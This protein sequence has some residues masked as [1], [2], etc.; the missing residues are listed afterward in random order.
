VDLLSDL[1]AT[2]RISGAVL[3]R[4]ELREPWG[5]AIPDAREMAR[6]LP[7]CVKN[8]IPFHI[9]DEGFFWVHSADGSRVRISSGEAVL[10]PRG[11]GHRLGGEKSSATEPVGAV[12]PHPP[13]EVAPLVRHG[14]N[15]AVAR[16]VCGFVGCEDPLLDPFLRDLPP[17]LHARPGSDPRAR[18]LETA[19]RYTAHEAERP[20]PGSRSVLSRLVELMFVE[21]LR[22]AMRTAGEIGVGWLAASGDPVVG[23]GGGALTTIHRAPAD[24][25]TVDTLAR[26]VGVSRTV[27][28][29]RFKRRLGLPPMHYLA[30][31]RLRVAA[32]LLRRT[33]DPLKGIA[34]RTGYESEAAFGR[35][36]KRHFGM[37]PHGWRRESQRDGSGLDPARRRSGGRDVGDGASP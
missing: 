9:A 37:P 21:V 10:L 14:G 4:A 8:V 15:G 34:L 17:L 36:F 13:W 29:E 26:R 27:L 5:I 11:S 18:W 32:N 25:W 16:I 19:I 24:P 20:G 28:A 31:W 30:R 12:F 1:L 23:G 7:G 33:S 6:I 2:V 3:F 22:E 35:A